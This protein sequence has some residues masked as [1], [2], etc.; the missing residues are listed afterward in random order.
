MPSKRCQQDVQN[1]SKN[2]SRGNDKAHSSRSVFP[3]WG[4]FSKKPQYINLYLSS[5]P[6]VVLILLKIRL[7]NLLM[8]F[9]SHVYVYV[10]RL[11][12]R[13]VIAAMFVVR[14]NKIFLFWEIGILEF[15]FVL[16]PT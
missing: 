12:P 16:A 3:V 6:K 13:Y 11:I 8:L 15:S 1:N 2:L 9:V 10:Y 4:L 5:Q 7:F 14:D